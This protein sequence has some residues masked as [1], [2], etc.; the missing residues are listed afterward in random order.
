M[1]I[2]ICFI[3]GFIWLLTL[4]SVSSTLNKHESDAI[5]PCIIML[6]GSTSICVT[7]IKIGFAYFYK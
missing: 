1:A 4:G 5:W 7:M 6:F 2:L 3:V